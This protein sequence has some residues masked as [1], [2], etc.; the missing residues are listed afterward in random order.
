MELILIKPQSQEWEYMWKWLEEHPVNL[1][2]EF[3]SIAE[4]KGQSWQYMGSYRQDGK[5]LHSFRHRFHPNSQRRE[6][7]MLNASKDLTIDEIE[8]KYKF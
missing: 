6:D 2:L 5:V 4:H 8:K 7:L 3:P 1:G